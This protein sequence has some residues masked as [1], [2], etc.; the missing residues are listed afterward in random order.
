MIKKPR[1][2]EVLL[3]LFFLLATKVSIVSQPSNP[4]ND[5]GKKAYDILVIAEQFEDAFIGEAGHPSKLVK[6]YR[7]L[8]K[9]PQSDVVFKRLLKEATLAGQL[10]ALCG[11]YFTDH[12]FFLS[13]VEG[14]K[15]KRD[16]VETQS[17]C[18]ISRLPVRE[19]VEIKAPNVVRLAQLEQPIDEWRRANKAVTKKGYLLDIV[20]GG[21]PSRF[22]KR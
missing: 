6:A 14:Y 21:Y 11:I 5:E 19:I 20:G 4:L 17:G 15:N 1:T 2:M 16:Y 10:Y 12:I 8:L 22:A 18:I 9:Q 3:C 13:M 7:E